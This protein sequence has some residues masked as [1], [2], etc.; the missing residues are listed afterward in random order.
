MKPASKGLNW[1]PALVYTLQLNQMA[2]ILHANDKEVKG[3]GIPLP[4]TS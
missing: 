3:E 2:Q 4:N 1:V